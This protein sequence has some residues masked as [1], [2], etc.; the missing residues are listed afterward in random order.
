MWF[1]WI[2]FE[3]SSK[4]VDSLSEFSQSY[5]SWQN[6]LHLNWPLL[7]TEGVFW[8]SVSDRVENPEL[9][10]TDFKLILIMRA[11]GPRI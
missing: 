2:I 6:T 10:D 7:S 3:R 5:Q 1:C 8:T 11:D 4:E 9:E